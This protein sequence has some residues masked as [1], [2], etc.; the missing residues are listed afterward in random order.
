MRIWE[1][2]TLVREGEEE[3]FVTSSNMMG[4]IPPLITTI[5]TDNVNGV[6]TIIQTT[7]ASVLTDINQ[8]SIT[9]AF[10]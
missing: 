3:T 8:A 2:D 5:T 4:P 1:G 6:T 7:Y 9:M 10:F